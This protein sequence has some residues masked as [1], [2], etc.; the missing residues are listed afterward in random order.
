[1]DIAT[2]QGHCRD[3]RTARSTL[4]RTGVVAAYNNGLGLIGQ[5]QGVGD[6]PNLAVQ[7]RIIHGRSVH[8]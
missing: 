1:M 3:P 5:M 8:K 4:H 7:C 2:G 6:L